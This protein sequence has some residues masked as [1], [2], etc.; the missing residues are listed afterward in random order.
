MRARAQR[1]DFVLN[2]ANRA[3][4]AEVVRLLD[5]LPLAIELA[6]ARVRVLSPAQLVARMRDRFA[7]LA[8]ARGMAARQATLRAAIDWSWDLLAPWEQGAFAQ[9]SVF[10]GG[11]TLEAAEAVLDLSPWPEAPSA[12]DVVQALSD[13]SLLRMWVPAAKSRYDIEEPFFGMYLSIREYAA[14]KLDAGG[15]AARRAAEERHGVHFAALR[16]R[17]GDRCAVPA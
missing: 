5:G 9:C 8:G 1:P 14:E 2:D 13:K 15:A 16:Q 6:A 12:M 10:D 7:I 4:V 17:R 3:A 11:F